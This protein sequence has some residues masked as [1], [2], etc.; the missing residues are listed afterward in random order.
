MIVQRTPKVLEGLLYSQ[1]TSMERVLEE[2][3]TTV[4]V[5]MV[6]VFR[7]VKQMEALLTVSVM[8]PDRMEEMSLIRM[9][10]LF[11]LEEVVVA[12]SLSTLMLSILMEQLQLLVK[13]ENRV[14]VTTTDLETVAQVL[15]ADLAVASL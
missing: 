11:L 12:E 13:M 7:L 8:K 2:Q 3:D 1:Q 6:A 15:A 10:T 4:V 9:E 14:T 5:A